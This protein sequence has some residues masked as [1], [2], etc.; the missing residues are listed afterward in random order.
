M[1]DICSDNEKEPVMK[2]MPEI[3]GVLSK[4]TMKEYILKQNG[5]INVNVFS[6]I[7]RKKYWMI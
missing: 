1:K 5:E 2:G 6:Y 3:E 4:R 7:F